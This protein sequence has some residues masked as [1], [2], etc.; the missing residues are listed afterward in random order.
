[1]KK[2]AGYFGSIILTVALLALFK[3]QTAHT[4]PAKVQKVKVD[5][6][7]MSKCPGIL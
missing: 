7:V 1:M 3:Y 4:I 6:Y 5:F 2:N